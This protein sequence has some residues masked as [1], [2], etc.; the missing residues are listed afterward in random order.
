MAVE[1]E[2]IEVELGNIDGTLHVAELADVIATA[3]KAGAGKEGVGTGLEDA[4]G[5]NDP[6]AGLHPVLNCLLDLEVEKVIA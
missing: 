4:L 5:G 3:T 1:L 2:A 6:A